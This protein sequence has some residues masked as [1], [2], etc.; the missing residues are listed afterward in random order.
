M[1]KAHRSKQLPN[2]EFDAYARRGPSA[3]PLGPL[4]LRR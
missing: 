1:V 3:A 4:N 2:P